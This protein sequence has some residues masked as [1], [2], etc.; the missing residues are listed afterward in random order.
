MGNASFFRALRNIF[1]FRS[2][3]PS[4]APYAAPQDHMF[5]GIQV[6]TARQMENSSEGFF[7]AC[8]GGHNGESHNHNDIGNFILYRNNQPIVIDAGVE[9]YTRKTF[10]DRRYEI[11]TMQSDYHNVPN[12]NGAMQCDTSKFV[13]R[14]VQ[15]T[16]DGMVTTMSLD[17]AGAY[18]AEAFIERYVRTVRFDR[19][20]QSL[21]VS[22]DF[23]LTTAVAPIVMQLML[24]DKPILADGK[25]EVNGVS[26]QYDSAQFE[27]VAEP[28]PLT[29]PLLSATWQR[30]KLYRVRFT[31]KQTTTTGAYTFIFTGNNSTS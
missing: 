19:T 13:A 22:D 16:A 6:M 30:D 11:W 23:A 1:D 26:V 28:V 2:I 5:D 15:Y 17:I 27:A 31:A 7:V 24:A 29:D 9:S 21:T 25:L 14:N 18:P 4:D 3:Q 8:K 10:S 20:A 12:I